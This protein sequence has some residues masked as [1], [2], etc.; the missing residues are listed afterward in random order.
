MMETQRTQ[1]SLSCLDRTANPNPAI[2]PKSNLAE[3]SGTT[4]VL[5][6]PDVKGLKLWSSLLHDCFRKDY[7]PVIIL[8]NLL[9]VAT[10]E[11]VC[12]VSSET[13]LKS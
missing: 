3:A 1:R 13:G 7:R 11:T 2:F 6:A 12:R 5:K 9:I 8:S 4:R 10:S